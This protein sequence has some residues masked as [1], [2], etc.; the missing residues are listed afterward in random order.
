MKFHKIIH[1]DKA[2]CTAEQKIAYNFAFAD[3]DWVVRSKIKLPEYLE[4]VR[5]RI[6]RDYNV[7]M[8]I[9]C[10]GE[11]FEA[12]CQRDVH[13]LGSYKEIGEAF[14]SRYTIE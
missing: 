12:Y 9:H 4:N 3:Y 13:V 2:V 6:E 10:L 1:V 14:P 11:G 8:I 5:K 7:D